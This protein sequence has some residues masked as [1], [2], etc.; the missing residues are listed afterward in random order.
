ML[1]EQLGPQSVT[2]LLWPLPYCRSGEGGSS[3][4]E[5]RSHF[6]PPVRPEEQGPR[7]VHCP[8]ARP[9]LQ[10]KGPYCGEGEPCQDQCRWRGAA[11]IHRS[12]SAY[13]GTLAPQQSGAGSPGSLPGAGAG[14]GDEPAGDGAHLLYP[15]SGGQALR[16]GPGLPLKAHLPSVPQIGRAHV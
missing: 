15:R 8:E 1:P 12:S 3:P 4:E 9:R 13:R 5:G 14:V 6:L 2:S 11:H 16:S 7:W 10:P